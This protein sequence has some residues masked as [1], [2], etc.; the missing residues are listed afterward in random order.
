[1]DI[2]YKKRTMIDYND[3]TE[4][5]LDDAVRLLSDNW[6]NRHELAYHLK[7]AYY[8]LLELNLALIEGNL[9]PGISKEVQDSMHCLRRIIEVLELFG[10][11]RPFL[12]SMNKAQSANA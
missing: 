6:V 3:I 1:M 4:K 5:D 9:V 11:T 8:N 2:T 7:S 10:Y 12:G